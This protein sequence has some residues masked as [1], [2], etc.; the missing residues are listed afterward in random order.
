M[1][2]SWT[3]STVSWYLRSTR[4]LHYPPNHKQPSILNFLCCTPNLHCILWILSQTHVTVLELILIYK[5]VFSSEWHFYTRKETSIKILNTEVLVVSTCAVQNFLCFFS[6]QGIEMLYFVLFFGLLSS[7]LLLSFV[8]TFQPLYCPR[9]PQ[10][11][12]VYL[13]IEMIQPGKTFLKFNCWS[14][15]V[16][17]E[18]C[19]SWNNDVIAFP[20]NPRNIKKFHEK[21]HEMNS[22]RKT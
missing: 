7:S 3:C 11:S 21:R 17:K 14:N 9:L 18:L 12:L 19:S 13:G 10:V 15:K 16:F 2:L 4:S 20:I 22:K 8:T 5:T 6:F 1:W